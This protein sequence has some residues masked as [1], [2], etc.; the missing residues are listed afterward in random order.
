MP[1]RSEVRF[2]DAYIRNLKA[3]AVRYDVFDAACAGFGMR[4]STSGTKSWIVL[5]RNMH[6]KTRATIGRYPQLPLL[7]ARQRAVMVLREMADGE[8]QRSNELVYFSNALDEWFEK[9]QAQNRSVEQ[10]RKTMQLH[11]IPHL[12]DFK[13]LDVQK[14]DVMRIVDRVGASA[15]VQANR[16]LSF[17]KRFFSWCVERD[18]LVISPANGLSKFKVETSRERVLKSHELINVW[19]ATFELGY[20]FGPL[21]RML[22]LTGQRLSEVAKCL[23]SD[24]DFNDRKWEITVARAKNKNGHIVHISEPLL[25]ELEQLR[26]MAKFEYLFTTTGVTP[27]SGFSKAKRRIDKLC[28]VRDWTFHD[29]RRTFATISTESLGCDP[30]VVDRILNHVNGS[31]KGVAAVYQRGQYLEQRKE[32]LNK[33]ANF[34]GRIV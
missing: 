16:V 27:V 22:T 13:L 24:I 19:Q 31:V 34:L 25:H 15:P 5:S 33:W 1:V 28:G 30:V 17:M 6:R 9:D 18:L 7:E 8:F 10:V 3:R 4:V 20:P 2:T 14:R 23:W 11:V 26:E 29:L 21:I 32:V 12:K